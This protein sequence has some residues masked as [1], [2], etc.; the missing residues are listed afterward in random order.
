MFKTVRQLVNFE[1]EV[2]TDRVI[3][4][5]A[6]K[7]CLSITSKEVAGVDGGK[8]VDLSIQ[9]SLDNTSQG[10]KLVG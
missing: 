2:R 9:T 10:K 5:H 7:I 1:Q 6:D 3:P 4:F 8:S